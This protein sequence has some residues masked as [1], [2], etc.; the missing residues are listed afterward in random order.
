MAGR[1][2][3]TP[4][5]PSSRL[6]DSASPPDVRSFF[7]Q[8]QSDERMVGCYLWPH[9]FLPT[10]DY[11]DPVSALHMR[12]TVPGAKH[13]VRVTVNGGF[14]VATPDRFGDWI[15]ADREPESDLRAR[16][17]FEEEVAD[18]CN[19]VICELATGGVPVSEPAA[20][21]YIG[22]AVVL[23]E[24]ALITSSAGGRSITPSG[25]WGGQRA[26]LQV[27]GESWAV[28]RSRMTRSLPP[29]ERTGSDNWRPMRQLS[30]RPPIRRSHGANRLRRSSSRGSSS[31]S[32]SITFGRPISTAP[33]G[34]Q[35]G[36]SGRPHVHGR[37]PNRV[38]EL[39]R[40]PAGRA[41]RA[42][43]SRPICT[44]QA[45]ASRNREPWSLTRCGGSAS[46]RPVRYLCDRRP[47]AR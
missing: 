38:V 16:M 40:A 42:L 36:P 26:S 1:L 30:S 33:G 3:D 31:S 24:H 39:D 15:H 37:G 23:G 13:D 22:R 35:G 12:W 41:S 17:V 20:P 2:R 10:P 4:S 28:P 44:E 29:R 47:A 8:H 27:T 43:R 7:D 19:L 34:H 5:D 18:E 45:R 9:R 25:R 32:I 11:S 14:F 46:S 21:V 6:M